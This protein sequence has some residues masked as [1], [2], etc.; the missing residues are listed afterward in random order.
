[1]PLVVVFN[2]SWAYI[3]GKTF[4]RT[5]LI[6]LSPN[7]T[8]EGFIGGGVATFVSIF[9]A[10]ETIFTYDKFTCL[11]YRIDMLPF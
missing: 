3:C 2:D 10:V 1:V 6:K 8:L 7:K 9:L 5:P 4:G 11:N